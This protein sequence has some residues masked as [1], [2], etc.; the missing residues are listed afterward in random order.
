MGD[1]REK[2]DSLRRMLGFITLAGLLIARA[3]SAQVIAARNPA[4]PP[5]ATTICRR[6][7]LADRDHFPVAVSNVQMPTGIRVSGE[8]LETRTMVSLCPVILT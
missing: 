8:T 4:A 1:T 3:A 2:E 7:I 5:P 6:L